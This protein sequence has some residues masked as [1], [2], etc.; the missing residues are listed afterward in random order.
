MGFHEK[1][2]FSLPGIAIAFCLYL[3]LMNKMRGGGGGGLGIKV[4]SCAI[5]RWF[6]WIDS[7]L[8]IFR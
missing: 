4:R 3:D 2:R 7:F 1:Y 8:V 6:S 5:F